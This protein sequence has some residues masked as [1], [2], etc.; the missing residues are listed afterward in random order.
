MKKYVYGMRLRGFSI[1]C[2]PMNGFI[3]RRDSHAENFYDVIVYSRLL[4]EQ[5]LKDYDL[6]FIGMEEEQ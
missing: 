4:T 5:E 2:Q 3:E 1:G 6:T